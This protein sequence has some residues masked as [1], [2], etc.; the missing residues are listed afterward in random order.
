[1][2]SGVRKTM[3]RRHTNAI[4]SQV[5]L[6]GSVLAILAIVAGSA[7]SLRQEMKALEAARLE[8][9]RRTRDQWLPLLSRAASLLSDE[10]IDLVARAVFQQPEITGLSLEV[11]GAS[12]VVMGSLDALDQEVFTWPVD[13]LRGDQTHQLG[14]LTI[15]TRAPALNEQAAELLPRLLPGE[16]LKIAAILIPVFLLVHLAITKQLGKLSGTVRDL[17]HSLESAH[18]PNIQLNRRK[19]FREHDE[20]DE[21]VR[22]FNRLLEGIRQERRIRTQREAEL[23]RALQQSHYLLREVHHRVKNNLQML[24]SLFT[25][26]ADRLG[27]SEREVM[28]EAKNRIRSLAL[29]HIQLYQKESISGVEI[30]SYTRSLLDNICASVGN[31]GQ[32]RIARTVA[33][34]EVELPLDK[35]IPLALV[36]NELTTNAIKHAFAPESEGLIAIAVR[37]SGGAVTVRITD[38]GKG[39]SDGFSLTESTGFGMTIVNAL[40]HQIDATIRHDVPPEG[41]TSFELTIPMK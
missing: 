36:L 7:L 28:K 9:F 31:T 2:S 38:N 24:I 23:E 33:G 6:I 25:L 22:T 30:V 40:L 11:D 16:V 27:D 10:D 8:A 5:V 35:A 4:S 37:R 34:D 39:V 17:S 12:P 29:V 20:F 19:I 32:T 41:G 14:T 1:M 18:L 21:L 26:H 13:Y 15:A 3:K